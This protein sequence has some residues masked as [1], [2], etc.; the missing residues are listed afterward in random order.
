[1]WP[2]KPLSP[3][4]LQ[5]YSE[6]TP[7]LPPPWPPLHR[8]PSAQPPH[9][10]RAGGRRGAGGFQ[11]PRAA[12]LLGPMLHVARVCSLAHHRPS[13]PKSTT[14]HTQHPGL[15]PAGPPWGVM[16]PAC[17]LGPAGPAAPPGP[18]ASRASSLGPR[19]A[20][21]PLPPRPC[22]RCRA[23]LHSPSHWQAC[24][25]GHCTNARRVGASPRAWHQECPPG[26]P[27]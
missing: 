2:A 9:S 24:G 17:S 8:P 1:M 23:G 16:S 4:P 3:W 19:S 5:V 10:G 12:R 11:A 14:P 27:P 20:L 6:C 7:L 22:L 15:L 13:L 18:S 21:S 25:D 26:Q